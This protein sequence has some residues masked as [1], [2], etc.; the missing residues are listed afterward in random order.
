M[1]TVKGIALGT[2]IAFVIIYAGPWIVRRYVK[3]ITAGIAQAFAQGI[4]QAL[5]AAEQ[6]Q[7]QEQ[8]HGP[9]ADLEEAKWRGD[10][11]EDR[12]ERLARWLHNER[13]AHAETKRTLIQCRQDIARFAKKGAAAVP[14]NIEEIRRAAQRILDAQEV[15]AQALARYIEANNAS[16][17]PNEHKDAA[18]RQYRQTCQGIDA[19]AFHLSATI[20]KGSYAE[21]TAEPGGQIPVS[22]GTPEGG[23]VRAETG[24]GDA[25]GAPVDEDTQG[26][27][28]R[29]TSDGEGQG[30][31]ESDRADR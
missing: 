27:P 3:A 30:E 1:E 15:S 25:T 20:G 11:E 29:T 28:N 12:A 21:G 31:G 17:F 2:F 23:T 14:D 7:E 5:E 19:A 26:N 16:P 13:Q 6:E 24:T 9:A 10:Y 4:G 8:E 22:E 18:F